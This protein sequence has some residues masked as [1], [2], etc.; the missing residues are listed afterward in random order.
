MGTR[1]K[2]DRSKKLQYYEMYQEGYSHKEIAEHFGVT[3]QAVSASLQ[4]VRTLKCPFSALCENCPFP[5]CA[6]KEPYNMYVNTNKDI[7]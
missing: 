1:I 7:Y 4:R 6:I 2:G 5:E 3:R